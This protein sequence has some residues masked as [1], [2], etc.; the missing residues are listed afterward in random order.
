MTTVRQQEENRGDEDQRSLDPHRLMRQLVEGHDALRKA[1]GSGSLELY[2]RTSITLRVDGEAGSAA[3]SSRIGREDGTAIRFQPADGS[4]IRFAAA[5]GCSS[6]SLRWAA[7]NASPLKA[8]SAAGG[9]ESWRGGPVEE[10]DHDP[11][12]RL[13]SP[14][15]MGVWL[16]RARSRLSEALAEAGPVEPGACWAEVAATVESLVA[17]GGLSSSRARL[18]G[19]AM[20]GLR[21]QDPALPT[22]RPLFVA[23]RSWSGLDGAGWADLAASRWLRAGARAGQRQA[24]LPVLFTPEAASWLIPALVRAMNGRVETCGAPVGPG[25]EVTDDPLAADALFGGRVDDAGFDTRRRVLADG[26]RVIGPLTGPGSFRRPSFR[27]PPQP[28]PAH[29]SV[30]PGEDRPFRKGLIVSE[31]ALHRLPDGF[32]V[33]E[34]DG[35]LLRGD[36]P[37]L[38]VRGGR[39]RTSPGQM[40][41]RCAARIGPARASQ[42]GTS[43]PALLFDGLAVSL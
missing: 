40:V 12:D 4:A 15:E 29:L 30:S 41:Q 17:D 32:W 8:K 2:R 42:R 38:L 3:A 11:V 27:D 13:P 21:S 16:A 19:W 34:C 20:A 7:A 1:A 14:A 39:I 37:A 25:W 5:S 35:A 9:G 23:S 6:N 26:I 24:L 22:P 28:L 36:E 33:L 43:S 10:E 18:R 31:V